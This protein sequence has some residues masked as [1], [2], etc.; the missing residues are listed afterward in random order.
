MS[1]LYSFFSLA[2]ADSTLPLLYSQCKVKQKIRVNSGGANGDLVGSEVADDALVFAGY[3]VDS[4]RPM[5]QSHTKNHPGWSLEY[6]RG[7][8]AP[9]RSSR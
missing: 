9:G 2:A 7:I 5:D 8:S 3:R 1:C 4:V 6:S